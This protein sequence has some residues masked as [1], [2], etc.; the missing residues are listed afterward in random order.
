MTGYDQKLLEALQVRLTVQR[1][2]LGYTDS[3]VGAFVGRSPLT[4]YRIRR[5]CKMWKRSRITG[6]FAMVQAEQMAMVA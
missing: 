1:I 2:P 4:V 6:V 3:E 5:R